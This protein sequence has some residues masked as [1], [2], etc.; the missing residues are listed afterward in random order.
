[1]A[2][3]GLRATEG[4]GRHVTTH[5]CPGCTHGDHPPPGRRGDRR[6]GRARADRRHRAGRLRG[7]GL[8]LLQLRLPRGGARP[9]AG[10]RHR[11]Q[12]RAA[13]PHRLHLPGRRR[14]RVDRHGRDRPRRQPRREDHRHLRQQRHLR[15]DRRPDGADHDAG[16]G[17]DD[18]PARPRR[19]A[20]RLPDA[21]CGAARDAAHAG[22]RRARRGAHA[23]ARGHGQ[24]DAAPGLPLPGATT[25][26]SRWSRCSPP[27]RPTGAC[28]PS[29]RA[30]G[31]RR[32]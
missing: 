19:R 21:R 20:G 13:G 3:D 1:M 11:H 31:W 24:G 25:P 10:R 30:T 9:R 32:T 18:L 14:P 15:H 8:Q 2:E 29:S 6:A 4:A 23:A 26:A 5:Y 17:D 16:P 22:L 28:R 27:A 12:A 7:A